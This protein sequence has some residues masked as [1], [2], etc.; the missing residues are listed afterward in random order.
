[1]KRL[2]ETT[3][4]VPAGTPA[5]APLVSPVVLEDA[6]LESVRIV[7]PPGHFGLTGLAVLWGGIQIVPFGQGTS[8]V[9]NDEIIDYAWDDEIT[10]NGLALSGFNT[11]VFPHSFYLRWVITDLPATSSPVVIASP[12]AAAAPSPDDAAAI[13]ALTDTAT[14]DAA[15]VADLAV[16]ADQMLAEATT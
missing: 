8:I 1:M 5:A 10:A 15:S 16:T 12:Q 3:F 6:Q 7:I 13:A 14:A 2:Y 4:T 9:A 11:D